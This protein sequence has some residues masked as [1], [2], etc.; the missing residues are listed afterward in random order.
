MLSEQQI[1]NRLR[2][3]VKVAGGKA[4][5]FVSPGC[6]GVPDRLV[7]MPGG[8]IYLVELKAPGKIP[9]AQ[10]N[11]RKKEFQ[12]LGFKVYVIDTYEAVEGFLN[13]VLSS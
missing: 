5:K 13:E 12:E 8:Q 4:L 7:F 2:Q 1:E 9:T 10:Q 6:R 3:G 11:K